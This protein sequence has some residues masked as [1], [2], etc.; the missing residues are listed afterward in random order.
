MPAG[1]GENDVSLRRWRASLNIFAWLFLVQSALGIA[2]APLVLIMLEM[3]GSPSRT[4]LGQLG[5]MLGSGGAM[6]AELVLRAGLVV[7]LSLLANVATLVGCI[8]L[9][10]R[11][12]WGWF[13]VIGIQLVSAAAAF[14]WGLPLLRGLLA[15]VAPASA[16]LAAFAII[17]LLA[18]VPA[19][20]IVFLMSGG[21][22][23][24]FD[25]PRDAGEQRRQS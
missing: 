11:W 21:V 24:Q 25:R 23:R 10:K 22:V 16:D 13:L 15:L 3:S 14:I 7:R 12:K 19:A 18:L 2:T 1:A 6:M 5:A 9:L 8:G 4:E 17:A 20:V